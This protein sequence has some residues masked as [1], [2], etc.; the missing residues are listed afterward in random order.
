MRNDLF[1][2]DILE[3]LHWNFGFGVNRIAMALKINDHKLRK[4]FK[5]FKI[6]IRSRRERKVWA[7]NMIMTKNNFIKLFNHYKLNLNQIM[8]LYGINGYNLSV[9]LENFGIKESA[10][11]RGE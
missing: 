10:L 9:L 8:V 4:L 2:K 7:G 1:T 11:K 5:K 3:D 6:K